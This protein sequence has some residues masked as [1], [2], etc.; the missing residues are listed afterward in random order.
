MHKTRRELLEDHNILITTDPKEAKD[1][2]RIMDSRVLFV[3]N[4]RDPDR[5]ITNAM[6]LLNLGT[7]QGVLFYGPHV[8]DGQWDIYKLLRT[9]D[10]TCH[11]FDNY[12]ERFYPNTVDQQRLYYETTGRDEKFSLANFAKYMQT[13]SGKISY[14]NYSAYSKYDIP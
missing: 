8:E 7:K 10:V 11:C 13:S 1:A 4:E 5:D 2:I 6:T 3:D 14:K 12:T 9:L